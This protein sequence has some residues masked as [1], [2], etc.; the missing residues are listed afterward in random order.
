MAIIQVIKNRYSK[1]YYKI[2]VELGTDVF[3]SDGYVKK[4]DCLIAFEQ[5]KLFIN[6]KKNINIKETTDQKWKFSVTGSDNSVVGYSIP[7]G[8]KRQCVSWI[9][10]LR[11][12]LNNADIVEAGK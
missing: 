8:S 9:I 12:H 6:D 11:S 10:H 4:S 5:A 7:F 1:Y 3:A 2:M